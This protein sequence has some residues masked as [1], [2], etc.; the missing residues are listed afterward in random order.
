M[1]EEY[2]LPIST[3]PS[4]LIFKTYAPVSSYNK[5]RPGAPDMSYASVVVTLLSFM[6]ILLW[7]FKR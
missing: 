5:G 2:F 7:L 6:T 1:T 4:V 3:M